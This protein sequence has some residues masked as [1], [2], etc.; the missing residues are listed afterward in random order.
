M[1]RCAAVGIF[2]QLD[3]LTHCH[4][5]VLHVDTVVACELL[6]THEART[7]EGV[8]RHEEVGIGSH[9][10]E[11]GVL[12]LEVGNTLGERFVLVVLG[13]C[14]TQG[15]VRGV[16]VGEEVTNFGNVAVVC[17]EVTVDDIASGNVAIYMCDNCGH[18]VDIVD[19]CAVE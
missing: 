9:G 17:G 6:P 18:T 14:V 10:V 7:R 8:V 3:E 12:C 19:G 16:T 13:L 5:A 1:Y 11:G 2:R 4:A 15:A